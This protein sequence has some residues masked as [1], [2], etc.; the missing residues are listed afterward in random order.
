M[1]IFCV[2][3]ECIIIAFLPPFPLQKLLMLMVIKYTAEDYER[4][5][6]KKREKL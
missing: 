6:E 1:F 2:F 5:G 3:V 4:V